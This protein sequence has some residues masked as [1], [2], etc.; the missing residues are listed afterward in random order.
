MGEQFRL[1]AL[2][3]CSGGIFTKEVGPT[4]GFLFCF[5][6]CMYVRAC[7]RACVFVCVRVGCGVSCLKKMFFASNLGSPR[8]C[9]SRLLFTSEEQKVWDWDIFGNL[10]SRDVPPLFMTSLIHIAGHQW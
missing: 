2:F 7:V 8:R 10:A 4:G 1:R 3:G 6:V 5:G 9:H